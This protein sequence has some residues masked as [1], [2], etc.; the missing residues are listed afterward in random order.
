MLEAGAEV[1]GGA[2]ERLAEAFAARGFRDDT[3]RRFDGG[4]DFLPL[5]TF[6]VLESLGY[7][8]LVCG[9]RLRGFVAWLRGDKGWGVIERG[10][11][12]GR[13]ACSPRWGCGR[14]GRG[15]RGV[16]SAPPRAA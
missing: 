1:A 9:Y 16:T 3:L 12:G 11:F 8:Q 5:V 10:G 14:D 13:G 15:A 6:A 2:R 7:R 4:R